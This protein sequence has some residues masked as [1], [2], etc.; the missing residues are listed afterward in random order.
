MRVTTNIDFVTEKREI[1]V[2]LLLTTSMTSVLYLFIV[3]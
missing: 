2:H 3:E 1:K